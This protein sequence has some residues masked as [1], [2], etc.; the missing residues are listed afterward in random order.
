MAGAVLAIPGLFPDEHEGRARMA[1]PKDGLAAPLPEI[2]CAAA[3][4][5]GA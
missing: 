3:R 1:F 5:S 4:G 2:A